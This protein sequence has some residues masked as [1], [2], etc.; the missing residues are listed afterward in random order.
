M[1]SKLNVKTEGDKTDNK[2]ESGLWQRIRKPVLSS[3]IVFTVTGIALVLSPTFAGRDVLL[4]YFSRYLFATGLW[5]GKG[6]FVPRPHVYNLKFSAE[7]TYADGSKKIWECPQ[8]QKLSLLERFQKERY[9]KWSRQNM[10]TNTPMRWWPDTAIYIARINP[11]EN[12]RPVEV[13]LIRTRDE[14]PPPGSNEKGAVT[15]DPFF[16]KQISPEELQ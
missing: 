16:L 11:K 8:M 10:D 3:F 15:V 2:N 9:R 12:T 13:K 7:I 14:T 4:A 5:Q 6:V 1:Q